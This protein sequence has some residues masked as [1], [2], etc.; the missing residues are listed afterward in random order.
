MDTFFLSL[1]SKFK[2]FLLSFVLNISFVCLF[3]RSSVYLF[4]YIF[5]AH[6]SHEIIC[7]NIAMI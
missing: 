5:E 2:C 6:L 7:A 3:I 4:M 1:K